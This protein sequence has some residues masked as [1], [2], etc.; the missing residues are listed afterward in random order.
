M[1]TG[2]LPDLIYMFQSLIGRLQTHQP[3]QGLGLQSWVSIPHRQATDQIHILIHS[4]SY[5]SFNPSQVGYRL[6]Q[7]LP[8]SEDRLCFNPSQVGYRQVV[9][10]GFLFSSNN[11]SI[12]HRQATDTKV[13]LLKR[14]CRREFQSLIGRLQTHI[15]SFFPRSLKSFNPSQVGYR[16]IFPSILTGGNTCFNPSQV[17]YRLILPELVRTVLW[18][19]NPSQVGYRLG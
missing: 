9:W 13:I 7:R 6:L 17:G 8:L 2:D 15:P 5:Y 1:E 10:R 12:P 14:L 16:H 11:V 4:S 3:M 19:F 18:C